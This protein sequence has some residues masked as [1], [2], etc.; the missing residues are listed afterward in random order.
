MYQVITTSVLKMVLHCQG[1]ID[2][3]GKI[4][5]KTKGAYFIFIFIF[6]YLFYDLVNLI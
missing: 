2:K 4:V 6:I 1:C 3:I 5:L